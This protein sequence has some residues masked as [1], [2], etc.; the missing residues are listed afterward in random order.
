MKNIPVN[1]RKRP[2]ASAPFFT[3]HKKPVPPEEPREKYPFR[4]MDIGHYFDV[5]REL[6]HA[7]RVRASQQARR[8]G[9]TYRVQRMVRA[10]DGA[11]CVRVQRIA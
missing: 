1:A 11:P 5:P 10:E 3:L 8:L 9:H 6:D 4:A 7:V 2:R